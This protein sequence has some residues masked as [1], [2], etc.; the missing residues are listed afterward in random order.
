MLV[1]GLDHVMRMDMNTFS[2]KAF[3]GYCSG[4]SAGKGRHTLRLKDQVVMDLGVSKISN[5]V[6]YIS[7][8]GD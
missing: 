6:G 5:F 2:L 3:A 8:E 1:R 4:R 7:K